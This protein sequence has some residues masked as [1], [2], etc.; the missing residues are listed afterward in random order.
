MG[1]DENGKTKVYQIHVQQVGWGSQ[2][3]LSSLYMLSVPGIALAVMG[4]IPVCTDNLNRCTTQLGSCGTDLVQVKNDL[5]RCTVDLGGCSSNLNRC[6][7]DLGKCTTD[8]I[9][10]QKSL[11]QAM[12]DLTACQAALEEYKKKPP[13]PTPKTG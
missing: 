10:F 1:E 7:A 5:N 3:F 11:D 12:L 13:A 2:L 9:E 8:L 6:T 4:G